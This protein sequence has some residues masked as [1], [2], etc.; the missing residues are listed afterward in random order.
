MAFIQQCPITVHRLVYSLPTTKKLR[1]IMVKMEP[2]P[3]E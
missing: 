2:T 1:L 3:S